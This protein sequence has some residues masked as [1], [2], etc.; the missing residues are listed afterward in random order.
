[1][2]VDEEEA[3]EAVPVQRVH[4]VANHGDHGGG[5]QR[6]GAG[7]AEMVLRHA[8]GERRRHHRA[9]LVAH[10]FG[11]EFRV[12]MVGA[13]QPVRPVLL[14]RA[15]GDDDAAGGAEILLHLLPGGEGELHPIAPR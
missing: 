8:I 1:M 6:D 15:D 9:D 7:E 11:D 2:P 4:D 13:D 10:P 3:L 5:P 12:E 14:G